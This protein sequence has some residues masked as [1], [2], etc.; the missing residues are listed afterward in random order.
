[1]S[2][3][4]QELP[5]VIRVIVLLSFRKEAKLPKYLLKKKLEDYLAGKIAI[6]MDEMDEALREMVFEG[7]LIEQDGNFELTAEGNRLSKEWRSLLIKREPVLEFVAGL[8]D[9]TIT[10]LVVVLS[11]FLASLPTQMA[12]FAAV[13]TV[14]AAAVSNFSSFMLGGKTEDVADLLVLKA[15][16]DYSL[17]DIPDKE[18]RIKSLRIIKHLF[19][20][21]GSEITKSNLLAALVCSATTFLAGIIPT[22]AFLTLPQPFGLI[23]AILIVGVTISVFLVHYRARKMRVPW[24]ISLLETLI[25]VAV[26]IIASLIIGGSS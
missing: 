2:F 26:A 14:T 13:L 22:V 8:T 10:G 12:L 1:M 16:M 20:I 4:V 17:R 23:L 3:E 25:I 7:L 15:L 18:E 24:K 6:E 9:G 11:A 21:L 19:S 5:D